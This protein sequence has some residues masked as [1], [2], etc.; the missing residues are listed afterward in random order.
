M[1]NHG[2]VVEHEIPV[3]ALPFH[4]V[5]ESQPDLVPDGNG[6]PYLPAFERQNVGTET[7]A[8][9]IFSLFSHLEGQ[10]ILLGLPERN[11]ADRFAAFYAKIVDGTGTTFTNAYQAVLENWAC[12]E[13]EWPM[14]KVPFTFDDYYA[15]PSSAAKSAARMEKAA[16]G[17]KMRV[18]VS[19][20][21]EDFRSAL[22]KLGTLWCFNQTHAFIVYRV[23]DRIRVYDTYPYNNG[24]IG[25]R[26]LPL[27]AF[28][29]DNGV[30]GGYFVPLIAQIDPTIMKFTE[31]TKYQLMDKPGGFFHFRNGVMV[32]DTEAKLTAEWESLS[33]VTVNDAEAASMPKAWREKVYQGEGFYFIG[34]RTGRLTLSDIGYLPNGT[35]GPNAIQLF[36]TKGDPVTLGN[37]V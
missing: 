23:D 15:E 27:S 19:P 37:P 36:N 29:T 7:F 5:G 11:W 17:M 21:P 3:G 22:K 2:N 6:E 25:K 26:D 9:T 16:H 30:L 14:P 24:G 34:G 20:N 35:P 33:S 4:A 32:R 8:C 10:R 31:K 13:S 28:G 1:E 18:W 12:L